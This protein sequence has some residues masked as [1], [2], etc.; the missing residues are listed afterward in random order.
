MSRRKQPNPK[1]LRNSIDSVTD[2]L[3]SESKL[4]EQNCIGSSMAPQETLASVFLKNMTNQSDFSESR[5]L[6]QLAKL[7]LEY[8]ENAAKDIKKEPV[9]PIEEE[10]EV[11]SRSR[12]SSRSSTNSD[13]NIDVTTVAEPTQPIVESRKPQRKR[14]TYNSQNETQNSNS[15]VINGKRYYPLKFPCEN[16]GLRYSDQSTLDTH[17]QNY[18]TKRNQSK[19]SS[20]DSSSSSSSSSS[21]ESSSSNSRSSSPI[22]KTQ[23][24]ESNSNIHLLKSVMYQCSMCTFQSDK[25]SAM[26]RHSRIHLPQKRK[27]MEESTNGKM[28]EPI[29]NDINDKEKSYCKECDIHFSSIKTYLHHRNNYCQKYKTIESVMPIQ[30]TLPE[31]IKKPQP[32]TPQLP[33]QPIRMGDLLYLPVYKINESKNEPQVSKPIDLSVSKSQ[34]EE[35]DANLPLDL[36]LKKPESKGFQPV[37]KNSSSNFSLVNSLSSL[38]RLLSNENQKNETKI[39]LETEEIKKNSNSPISSNF[40]NSIIQH[41]LVKKTLIDLYGDNFELFNIND[42]IEEISS[43]SIKANGITK[44]FFMCTACGY[45]GNTSRGVKQHGKLHLNQDENFSIIN[46]TDIQPYLVYSSLSDG[47]LRKLTTIGKRDLTESLDDNNLKVYQMSKKA[48]LLDYNFKS[49]LLSDI[50]NN[51]VNKSQTY[52]QKCDIQFQHINNFLAHKKSYCKD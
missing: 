23:N 15:I 28:T 18:C 49:D 36:S 52:C 17:K 48:R 27:Q 16:C 24:N 38:P 25:K 3:N 40:T 11:K 14:F 20:T 43:N 7:T 42:E 47:D 10:Q 50:N 6:Y 31:T 12:S 22:N 29:D 21:D 35:A 32:I 13:T 37:G 26:N 34:V 1:S 5:K 45:R 46:V 9:I 30:V 39:L 51:N 19:T 8:F 41:H 4:N 2:L 33:P 44:N